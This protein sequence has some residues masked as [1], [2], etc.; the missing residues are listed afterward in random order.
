MLGG[1]LIL[2][3][4][5]GS[6]LI[7]KSTACWRGGKG[8]VVEDRRCQVELFHRRMLVVKRAL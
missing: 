8:A 3:L 4:V 7:L 5:G 1:K 2:G 6:S